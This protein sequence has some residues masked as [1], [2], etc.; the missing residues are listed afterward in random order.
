M[1]SRARATTSGGRLSTGT[2]PGVP[3]LEE[4]PDEGACCCGCGCCGRGVIGNAEDRR[5]RK[6][7]TCA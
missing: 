3:V 6:L 5:P 4:G 1:S 2:A 7:A